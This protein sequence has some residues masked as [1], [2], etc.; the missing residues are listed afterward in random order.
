MEQ[1]NRI[2]LRG[3]VGNVKVDDISGSRVARLTVATNYAYKDR[4]GN[5]VIETTWHN[6]SAWEGRNI[7][8][9]D[10][11]RRGD[12]IYVQGRLKNQKFTGSDGT[13]HYST[14]IQAN[15]LVLLDEEDALQCEMQ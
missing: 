13:D 5:P 10:K 4:T 6:V 12:R 3:A 11:I 1:L 8:G 9:L 14:E 2:E 7:T 15:R